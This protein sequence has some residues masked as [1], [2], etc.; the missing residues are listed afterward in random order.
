MFSELKDAVKD[1]FSNKIRGL[2]VWSVLLAV[3]VFAFLFYGFS[4]LISFVELTDMPKVQKMVEALGYVMFF[5]LSLILFPSVVT[6]FSGFFIDSVVERMSAQNNVHI[7]R[8]V[9]LSESLAVSGVVVFK[10]IALSALLIPVT[11]L[12]SWI[13][14]VNFLPVVLYY[15]LNGRLLAREYF[16]AV[17]LRYTEKQ[18]AEDLFNRY[19]VYWV[20]AGIIIAILMTIP[21]VNAV[22]PLI[23]MAFMQRLFLIKSPDRETV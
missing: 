6:F 14:F 5:I 12:L 4:H 2:I 21:V 15:G 20:K 23:A 8:N 18:K 19:H 11:V 7:L 10:G 9:P 17:A 1:V 13:P 16:F 22:S 3:A